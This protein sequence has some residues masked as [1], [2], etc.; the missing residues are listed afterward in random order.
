[1]V[2]RETSLRV[3][4]ECVLSLLECVLS[5]R[6]VNPWMVVRETSLAW[7]EFN[8]TSLREGPTFDL[9]RMAGTSLS[10]IFLRLSFAFPLFFFINVGR[11]YFRPLVTGGHLYL[12]GVSVLLMCCKLR[13]P[14]VTGIH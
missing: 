10:H 7:D 2:V 14:V 8:V 5:L 11:F 1:M 13:R 9:E 4:K 6:T 12:G 3:P